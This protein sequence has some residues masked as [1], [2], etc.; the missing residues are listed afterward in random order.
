MFRLRMCMFIYLYLV[1]EIRQLLLDYGATNNKE[2]QQYW[3]ITKAAIENEPQRL[4]K[5]HHDPRVSF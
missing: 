3:R 2:L 4:E 1:H 5:F